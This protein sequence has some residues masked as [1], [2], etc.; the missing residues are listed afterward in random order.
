MQLL[1]DADLAYNVDLSE[2]YALSQDAYDGGVLAALRELRERR[3]NDG[4]RSGGAYQ[5]CLNPP[6]TT[7]KRC[8]NC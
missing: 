7:S 5:R 6:C 4:A 2:P 8:E 1:H 3:E